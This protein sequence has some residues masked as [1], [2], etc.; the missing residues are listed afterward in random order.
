MTLGD[1]LVGSVVT[2]IHVASYN[3]HSFVHQPEVTER[4]NTYSLVSEGSW[5]GS[6]CHQVDF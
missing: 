2:G 5:S 6:V 4:V 1:F 3:G